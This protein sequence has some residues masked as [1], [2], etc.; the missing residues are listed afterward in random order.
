MSEVV[1]HVVRVYL[2]DNELAVYF[3]PFRPSIDADAASLVV[4]TRL[5]IVG[6]FLGVFVADFHDLLR[7]Q[8]RVGQF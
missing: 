4:V 5:A 6:L 2:S 7:R 3:V 1:A 8:V